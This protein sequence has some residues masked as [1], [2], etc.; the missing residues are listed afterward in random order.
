M[1]ACSLF[2][3]DTFDI[4]HFRSWRAFS[5]C[6][7]LSFGGRVRG[8][9][10]A[11]AFVSVVAQVVKGRAAVDTQVPNHAKYH[12]YEEGKDVYDVMLNQTNIGQVRTCIRMQFTHA[13]IVVSERGCVA[14]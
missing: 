2:A 12:V 7:A 11:T 8:W 6:V 3:L 14:G 10:L 13:R 9:L 1:H 4:R 5:R